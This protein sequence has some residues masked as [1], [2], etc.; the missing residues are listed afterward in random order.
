MIEGS[1]MRS[2]THELMANACK[3]MRFLAQS[4][5]VSGTVTGITEANLLELTKLSG[6]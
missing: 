3:Q 5:T 1:N 2:V 6:G 4:Q